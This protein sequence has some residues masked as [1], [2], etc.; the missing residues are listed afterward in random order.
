MMWGKIGN[1]IEQ[2]W[3]Y[4]SK[5]LVISVLTAA[6]ILLGWGYLARETGQ[7]ERSV[8]RTFGE[9]QQMLVNQAANNVK[10]AM[11]SFEAQN[12]GL[13]KQAES[14]AASN[15][16]RKAMTSGSRY[17]FF[18]SPDG[19]VFEKN[20]EA[21]KKLQGK[22]IQQLI[23]YWK[24]QGGH[25]TAKLQQMIIRKE[26]GTIIFSKDNETGDEVVTLKSFEVNGRSYSLGMSTLKSYVMSTARVTEH[27][28]YLQTF[29]VLV[30]LNILIFALLFCMGIYRNDKESERLNRS[31]VNKNLQIQELNRK[32]TS[33]SEAVQ[34]AS[35]YDNLT[36]L[37]NR[38]FFDNLL[39]RFNN[40][41]LMPVSIL[42]LDI[43]GLEQLNSVEG[44][45]AGDRLLEQTSEILHRVCIDSDILSRTGGSEFTILMTGTGE[46]E[47]YGTAKNIRRQFSSLDNGE[48]T[49]SIGA[50]QLNSGRGSI[51]AV[52]QNARKNLVLEKL[53]DANSNTNSIICMLMATLHAYS[54]E[55][56]EHS[57]R[58]RKT[59]LDF[60]K[61][62]GLP[63]SELSRLAVAAQLHDVGKIGIPDSIINKRETLEDHE[64][65]L[66]RRHSELGYHIVKAIPF[67]DEVAVDI[68]GHHEEYDGKG[69]PYG[70]KGEE[71]PFNAR[72]INIIDSFDAMTNENVYSRIKTKEEAMEELVKM[73]GS[74]YDPY[75]VKEFVKGVTDGF[76][77]SGVAD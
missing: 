35:I 20:D 4:K 44:Y 34:N 33:K 55:T 39:T 17:W 37:Y 36:K 76:H 49:I 10:S 1:K 27:I 12:P 51:F 43:N 72:L 70:L 42:I 47:A 11:S 61:Y 41:L 24:L 53:L 26:D 31:I 67:L 58:M 68:L 38:K 54:G 28:L 21:T 7:Y 75:L 62:L 15:V 59:A 6:L 64:R 19:V 18:Y 46:A 63:P 13:F 77:R 40:E 56:V 60:G 50:A 45:Q 14:A 73:S 65:E 25:D 2:N 69:Y 16:I 66:I 29:S 8:I 48:L 52:L 3:N 9:N 71:I 32:L 23:Q 30:S 5:I 22:S 57:D 74:R